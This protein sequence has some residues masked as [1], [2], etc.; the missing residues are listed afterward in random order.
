M[1][2][3]SELRFGRPTAPMSFEG[4][5]VLVTGG[6]AP[7]TAA[8]SRRAASRSGAGKAGASAL[9]RLRRA[10]AGVPGSAGGGQERE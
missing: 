3:D 1:A 8:G 2:R 4:A 5:S 10:Y 9:G 6:L 7:L